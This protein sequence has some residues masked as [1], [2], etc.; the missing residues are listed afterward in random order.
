MYDEIKNDDSVLEITKIFDINIKNEKQ[1]KTV[2]V[3]ENNFLQNLFFLS[4]DKRIYKLNI[5]TK[6]LED[7]YFSKNHKVVLITGNNNSKYLIIIFKNCKIYAINLENNEIFYFKNLQSVPININEEG[8][9][10]IFSP[11]LK[12]FINDNLDKAVLYTGKEIIIWYKHQ[13]LFNIKKQLNELIGYHIYIQLE[14]E[15]KSFVKEKSNY[16]DNFICVFNNDI[17]QGKSVNI[18]YFMVFKIENTNLFK[19]VIINYVF[20]FT[21]ENMFNCIDKENV[22][23]KYLINTDIK[24][25]FLSKYSFT[26]LINTDEKEKDNSKNKNIQN[27][28]AKENKN[29]NMILIG[30]NFDNYLENLL[31]LFFPKSYKFFPAL[32]SKIFP[33]KKFKMIIEDFA[34]INNDYFIIIYFINGYFAL[35]NT[36][37]Q[38][39]KFHDPLNNFSFLEDSN[40]IYIFNTFLSINLCNNNKKTNTHFNLLSNSYYS[41]SNNENE[42]SLISS[43]NSNSFDYFIVYT[44]SKIIGFH[45]K[46]K[47]INYID[48][49]LH[50]ELKDFKEI[51]YLIQFLQI[52]DFDECKKGMLFDKIHNYFVLNYGQIFQS[53][54]EVLNTLQSERSLDMNKNLNESTIQDF[55]DSNVINK[56]FIKFIYIFRY[57]NIIKYYP[58]SLTSYFIVL[59]ND[60]FQFLLNQKEVWLSFLMVG[61]GEKYLLHKLKLRNYKNNSTDAKYIQGKT[62]FIIFNPNFLQQNLIKGY[63]RINNFALFS[64]MR[65]LIIF[66][67]LME[68]RNNQARNINVLYF[69][70][71]KLVVN[72]LKEEK[73][74]DDL[75]FMIKVII[76]NWKYLKSE[77]MKSTEEYILNSFSINYKA[78]TLGILLHTNSFI[79][80]N[81]IGRKIVPKTVGNIN[82][83]TTV[84][85]TKSRFDF[86]NDFYSLDELSNFNNFIINFS[87][88]QDN[89]LL[90]EFSYFNHLGVVQKW[91]IYFIN[92]LFPEL[93]NDYKQYINTHLKQT[94]NQKKPENTSQDEKNL[95]KMI[96]FNLYIFMNILVQFIKDI[97]IFVINYSYNNQTKFFKIV[98]PS[99]LPYL[100]SEF[101]ALV[102]NLF[103][104][105]V[106]SLK[107]GNIF[108]KEINDIFNQLW[109]RYK[110]EIEFDINNIFDFCNFLTQK[111]FKY[112]LNNE[113]IINNLIENIENNDENEN[114]NKVMNYIFSLLEFSIIIIHKNDILNEIDLKNEKNFI[115]DTINILPHNLKKNIYELCFV[116]FVGHTRDYIYRQIGGG[117]NDILKPQEE[118]NFFICINFIRN[119]FIKY[120]SE[121]NPL[122]YEN[123]NELIQILPDFIKPILLEES[124]EHLYST[125]EK[126]FGENI[127]DTNNILNEKNFFTMNNK[128]SQ[129]SFLKEQ[130]ISKKLYEIIFYNKNEKVKLFNI[131]LSNMINIIFNGNKNY[132]FEL[133]TDINNILNIMK[134]NVNENFFDK[135]IKGRIDEFKQIYKDS[136]YIDKLIKKIKISIIKIFHLLSILLLKYKLL[137]L[138]LKRNQIEIIQLYVLLL[139]LVENNTNYNDK[140]NDI[141]KSLKYI[142][143]NN[144]S[145]QS[146]KSIVDILININLGFIFKQLEPNN[147]FKELEKFIGEKHKNLM[148]LYSYTISNNINIFSK[149]KGKFKEEQNKFILFFS[150]NNYI[151]LLNEIY[152]IFYNESTFIKKKN[153]EPFKEQREIYKIILEK[154]YNLTGFNVNMKIEFEEDWELSINNPIY[155]LIISDIF[156]GRKFFNKDIF[157]FLLSDKIKN[158]NLELPNFSSLKEKMKKKDISN[159]INKFTERKEKEENITLYK[160]KFKNINRYEKNKIIKM[161]LNKYNKFEIF[162]LLIKK[163]IMIKFRN[164]VFICFKSKNETL[165]LDKLNFI[166]YNTLTNARE[167]FILKE[168]YVKDEENIKNN[169]KM[170]PFTVIKLNKFTPGDSS[171]SKFF[172]ELLS[173]KDTSHLGTKI[174]DKLNEI[175]NK[176]K[177][178]EDFNVLI[179]NKFFNKD[180]I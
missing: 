165:N 29:G 90:R 20:F 128:K 98:L 25:K 115:F 76:R 119:L 21:K 61:L 109:E 7:F 89:I 148:D 168:K 10:N 88:G 151:Q 164:Q 9:E 133:E 27:I 12:I 19:L 124:L 106:S 79:S 144:K 86:F 42:N 64:K 93:F 130:K 50:I 99:D 167:S 33:I 55:D 30:I 83:Y 118:Y 38:I 120:I 180:I 157:D 155:N 46:S 34:F 56:V 4:L 147:S 125:F 136:I 80:S 139:L 104:N 101:Y 26:Y 112:Y 161:M 70:L 162:S 66:F 36:N 47:E 58:L 146:Y 179:Q 111:G 53:L 175:Q 32:I 141:C 117:K 37:F 158:T 171:K 15:K 45:I 145:E 116:V 137:T 140:I 108:L 97:F 131:L 166:K 68:F 62:S 28:I 153:K 31:I 18:Y 40:N 103:E 160:L 173:R 178:Y 84:R 110:K 54:R 71:A 3:P 35:L 17:F 121:K 49:L 92:F 41:N 107:P 48:R 123:L 78:E 5:L 132:E 85:N 60:F 95:N 129:S 127:F 156:T 143:N 8:K 44:N 170:K 114:N 113:Q 22:K 11:K 51:I 16:S 77:N 23:E 59:T 138:D 142:I 169:N 2:F 154:Y 1:I 177:E 96:F 63:N 163:I 134:N 176:I 69:I 159:S 91:M 74:L 150:I 82:S 94:I 13:K 152:Q 105:N 174:Q 100:I 65:L 135:I 57:L 122:V 81:Y 52:N 75:N 39:I 87:S 72:K 14:E 126:N 43:N 172:A 24:N 149:L 102:Y 6:K 67:C 73:A